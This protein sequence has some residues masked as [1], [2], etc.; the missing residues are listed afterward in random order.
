MKTA[1]TIPRRGGLPDPPASGKRKSAVA[2]CVNQF[3]EVRTYESIRKRNGTQAVQT[4]HVHD[5]LRRLAIY[6]FRA[7][8]MVPVLDLMEVKLYE[9]RKTS[10]PNS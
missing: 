10:W 4:V 6:L 5:L 3:K 7:A 9:L 1:R 2:W 8:C